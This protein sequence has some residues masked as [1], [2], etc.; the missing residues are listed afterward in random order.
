MD[1]RLISFDLDGTFLDDGKG[2]PPENLR[3]LEAAAELGVL[4]VP[5]TG[6]IVAGLPEVL[7]TLPCMRYYITANGS[8]VYD[9]LEDKAV[10]RAEIPLARAL[11]FYEYA[12]GLEALYDCYQDNW[13]YM[14][15]WMYHEVLRSIPNEGVRELIVR[16]R[17][18]V[19]ELKAY[20]ADK[21]RDL[22]K[23]QLFFTDMALRSRQIEEL[24]ERF[25]DLAFSTSMPFNIEINA[26]SATKG[27][28]LT[29]LCR[30]LGLDPAQTLALG[31]GTNDSDML[32]AAGV[33]VAMANA[34]EAVKA[35]A[36]FVTGDNNEGGFA[37]AVERFVLR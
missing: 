19:P 1:I 26:K 4:L 10:A 28:A 36:D 24:P 23:L 27:S 6:R 3:A 12:D 9:A 25:P 17:T 11:E 29:A 13:G 20:L 22:Q 18:P 33:G 7:L 2:I 32:L 8:Y 31:D 15:E 37:R 16:L 35:I 5:A 21:G 30:H 14:T 34:D